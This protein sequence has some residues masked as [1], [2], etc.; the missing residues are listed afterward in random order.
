MFSDDYQCGFSDISDD[1][2]LSASQLI[3]GCVSGYLWDDH[4]VTNEELVA[5]SQLYDI[6][7]GRYTGSRPE[8]VQ[9]RGFATV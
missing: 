7:V 8:E 5:A 1:K 9:P 4:S 2:V 3:D 6:S